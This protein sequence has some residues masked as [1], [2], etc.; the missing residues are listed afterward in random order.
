MGKLESHDMNAVTYD[1]VH[2]D[3][4]WEEWALLDP[5]QKSLYKDVMLETYR[6]LTTI[7]Y[8]W[9]DHNIEELCQSSRRHERHEKSQTREKT[10]VYTQCVKA[11]ANDSHLHS[12][13]KT[14]TRLKPYEEN[15]CV[16]GFKLKKVARWWDT[17]EGKR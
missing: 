11:F 8:S 17:F 2:V 13:E 3:F 12:D 5:S 7:G 10:S 1:D 6:N 9:K 16:S 15:E 14:D 4:T